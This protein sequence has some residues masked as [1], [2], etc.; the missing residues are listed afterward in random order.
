MPF[1]ILV[2]PVCILYLQHISF[3]TPKFQGF[4]SHMCLV[5][6]ILEST[7]LDVKIPLPHMCASVSSPEKASAQ[8]WSR[9]SGPAASSRGLTELVKV[10]VNHDQ[11]PELF[12]FNSLPLWRLHAKCLTLYQLMASGRLAEIIIFLEQFF[13]GYMALPVW[14]TGVVFSLLH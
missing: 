1:F 2:N 7:G 9:D 12:T 6:A 10:L 5:A 14:T 11:P 13:S 8:T 4:N 3:W